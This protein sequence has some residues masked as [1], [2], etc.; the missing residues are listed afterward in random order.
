MEF[1]LKLS[2]KEDDKK[3]KD[4]VLFEDFGKEHYK[5]CG[6]VLTLG[7]GKSEYYVSSREEFY[8]AYADEIEEIFNRIS[9][10]L[11]DVRMCYTS[12]EDEGSGESDIM[13]KME[14]D[15]KIYHCSTLWLEDDEAEIGDDTWC[16]QVKRQME[17]E[18]EEW[19]CIMEEIGD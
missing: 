16:E 1:Y 7:V 9:T 2:K 17:D 14:N 19:R 12:L 8:I 10:I 4:I 15:S 5:D 6:A 13:L 18:E 3:L 11:P